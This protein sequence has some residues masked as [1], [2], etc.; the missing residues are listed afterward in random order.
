MRTEA[1]SRLVAGRYR[2]GPVIGRGAMGVVNRAHD[3]RL[4]RDVAIKFLRTDLAAH[5]SV[6]DRFEREATAAARLL[7]PNVVT[8]FDSGEEDGEPYIVMECLPG[9]TLADELREGPQAV[10]RTREMALEVLSALSAAHELGIVHRDIKPANL[11]IT[12]QGSF[13]VAD[14]GIAKSVDG[15]D[16]TETG[17]IL[18]TAAYL[19]PERIEGRAATYR[20]DLYSLGV[21]MYE[22][23]T[24]A[25]PFVGDNAAAIAYAVHDADPVPVLDSRPDADPDLVAAVERAMARNPDD[26]F[27]SADAMSEAIEPSPTS[28]LPGG[29]PSG[30]VVLEDETEVLTP[31]DVMGVRSTPTTTA[32]RPVRRRT[33]KRLFI[34]LAA[35]AL[36]AVI[37]FG[38]SQRDDS[39]GGIPPATE[40]STTI[41]PGVPATTLPAPLATALD[42]LDE[43]VR[44]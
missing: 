28:A 24:G 10:E 25:K 41:A 21:V 39:P 20:S 14:F 9:R 22:A 4:G 29:I 19:A 32:V 23:L 27:D 12:E 35:V 40:P 16:Q 44:S 8:V 34:A 43:A 7:H 18:G 30:D 6:R 5:E 38:V 31:T 36:A 2:L 26:R 15:L 1:A 11:L 17:E 42:R 13:K 37:A 33:Y 3:E